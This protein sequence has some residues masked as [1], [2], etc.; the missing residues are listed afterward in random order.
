[1]SLP[2]SSWSWKCDVWSWELWAAILC[3]P[4]ATGSWEIY[5]SWERKEAERSR[6]IPEPPQFLL[7]SQFWLPMLTQLHFCSQILRRLVSFII[8]A[9]FLLKPAW[10]RFLLLETQSPNIVT[11]KWSHWSLTVLCFHTCSLDLRSQD[12][13]SFTSLCSTAAYL[14]VAYIWVSQSPKPL[15]A[16][17]PSPSQLSLASL[18]FLSLNEM[19]TKKHREAGSIIYICLRLMN[20]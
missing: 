19:L 10:V 20:R 11:N 1:M 17:F 8:N 9:F 12:K 15:S 14:V 7:A 3:P 16:P 4:H 13:L 2:L 5:S 18:S 6:D